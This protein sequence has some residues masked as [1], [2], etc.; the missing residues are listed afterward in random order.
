MKKLIDEGLVEK[1]SRDPVLY[2]LTYNGWSRS[3]AQLLKADLL[4]SIVLGWKMA[5]RACRHAKAKLRDI[6]EADD[7]PDFPASSSEEQTEDEEPVRSQQAKAKP[8]T[9]AKAIGKADGKGKGKAREI[10]SREEDE[11]AR[12]HAGRQSIGAANRTAARAR[13]RSDSR[14][15]LTAPDGRLSIFYC[16][17]WLTFLAYLSAPFLFCYLGEGDR[18][19]EKLDDA[20]VIMDDT[21]TP[22][23]LIEFLPSQASRHAMFKSGNVWGEHVPVHR[24][25]TGPE[26]KTLCAYLRARVAPPRCSGFDALLP[27]GEIGKDKSSSRDSEKENSPSPGKR[28]DRGNSAGSQLVRKKSVA[29]EA[30]ARPKPKQVTAIELDS[31]DDGEEEERPPPDPREAAA[32]AAEKRALAA[33]ATFRLPSNTSNTGLARLPDLYSLNTI[34]MPS[35]SYT[36]CL[37]VDSREKPGLNNK[38]LEKMLTD[39][40]VKWES[41][42]LAMGDFIWIAKCKTTDRE[43]V[44]DCC[45]ER[46]RLDDLVSSIKGRSVQYASEVPS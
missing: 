32:R 16:L 11:P 28:G 29:D 13:D 12:S 31:S 40:G 18:R 14:D 37:V 23:Y 26:G 45:L 27:A 10:D 17:C 2:K 33:S 24:D 4:C 34:A 46:K 39:H 44:L 19:V 30:A 25:T 5:R 36:V 22:V 20:E 8:A 9:K 41:R 1:K 6:D 38:R 21:F 15:W 42:T 3:C 43:V 35:G 7:L